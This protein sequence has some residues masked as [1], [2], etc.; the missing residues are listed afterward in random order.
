MNTNRYLIKNEYG[1]CRI[2]LYRE[3]SFKTLCSSYIFLLTPL[4]KKSKKLSVKKIY[5]YNKHF[6]KKNEKPQRNHN[7]VVLF[8][9]FLLGLTPR[10]NKCWC[11]TFSPQMLK[12]P[13][14]I[15]RIFFILST[16]GLKIIFFSKKALSLSLVC[17]EYT[18]PDLCLPSSTPI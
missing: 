11:L 9:P 3:F 1:I 8:S 4:I 17:K 2:I 18:N 15:L 13:T 10:K 5:I 7:T 12:Y 6:L 16:R 14:G